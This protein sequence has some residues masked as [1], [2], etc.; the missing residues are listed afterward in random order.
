VRGS[1]PGIGWNVVS[2][3]ARRH[4]VTVLAAASVPGSAENNFRH[5]CQRHFDLHGPVPGLTLRWVDPPLLSRFLQ[6]ESLLMRRT[7]YYTG[8]AAWQRAAFAV[9]RQM[10]AQ[11]PFDLVHHL[12]ITGFREPG[13]L[14]QLDAP[15]VWG[16]IAGA[17]EFPRAYFGL[18]SGKEQLFYRLRNWANARQKRSKR[19]RAAARAARHIWA[20]S[21]EDQALARQQWDRT[22]ERLRESAAAPR[23]DGTISTYDGRRPLRLVW[24][25]QHIGR[26]ALPILLHA[27]AA[28]RDQKQRQPSIELTVLGDG[29][30]QPHWR[31]LAQR[32]GL[33]NIFWRGWLER[34]QAIAEVAR[35]DVLVSTSL[36]EGTPQVL[37]EAMALG[38]PVICH[39]TC[40]M[41]D[42]VTDDCGVRVPLTDSAGSIR[43]YAD[44]L[45][46]LAADPD[47][48]KRLS[49]GALQRV[50]ELSWD[51]QADRML[52]VYDEIFQND[53]RRRRPDPL[54]RVGWISSAPNMEPTR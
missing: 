20:V 38:L 14:W 15:F 36:L 9:A 32:L 51:K 18:L 27:L 43:A 53:P 44:A 35:G 41:A 13:Y 24:S 39:N 2:R 34:E 54:Q 16:P 42:A 5:D 52:E 26:K 7:L 21:P 29:P 28:L 10:H 33:R 1:E 6:R 12:N 46:R 3:L 23:S 17:A 50:V 48:V 31:A 25:G 47:E 30:E 37:L 11:Q 49:A 40:G 8:Y 4:D 19:C 45:Q 22:A